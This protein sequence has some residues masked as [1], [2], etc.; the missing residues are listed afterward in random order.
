MPKVNTRRGFFVCKD[1]GQT[2][3]MCQWKWV[4][5]NYDSPNKFVVIE[6]GVD[7][8]LWAGG[9]HQLLTKELVDFLKQTPDVGP[10]GGCESAA[11]PL[12]ICEEVTDPKR[13]ADY[14]ARLKQSDHRRRR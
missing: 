9:K 6:E 12:L 8:E 2:S 1:G 13:Y 3:Q 11:T 4:T 7:L 5:N 14:R 10:D